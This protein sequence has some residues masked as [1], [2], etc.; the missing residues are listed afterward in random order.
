[1]HPR[2]L[3]FILVAFYLHQGF[4]QVSDK[5]NEM[6]LEEA[7]LSNKVQVL[8][9]KPEEFKAISRESVPVLEVSITSSPEKPKN[10]Q[11]HTVT[12]KMDNST[13]NLNIHRN[14]N[15]ILV[16]RKVNFPFEIT[17]A[18]KNALELM[19][20]YLYLFSL[21]NDE[22]AHGTRKAK[23]HRHIQLAADMVSIVGSHN[24]KHKTTNEIVCGCT[25]CSTHRFP[26]CTICF[27]T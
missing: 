19:S 18:Q 13:V 22:Q 2:F 7:D 5:G 27:D 1:M 24:V 8:V 20:V 23:Q 17:N 21:G 25:N 10:H 15:Q 11:S 12:V 16:S 6:V 4:S 14:G 9:D 3:V 26:P